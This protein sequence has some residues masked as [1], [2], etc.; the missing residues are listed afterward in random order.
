MDRRR[1]ITGPAGGA[2]VALATGALALAAVA[3]SAMAS[4]GRQAGASAAAAAAAWKIVYKHH[5]GVPDSQNGFLTLVA[6]SQRQA[7]AFGGSDNL[8]GRPI[9]ARLTGG[10]WRYAA[11]PAGLTGE[12]DAASASS[13]SNVWA[14][15]QLGQVV[16]HWNG[17][18]WSV[19]KRWHMSAEV[20]LTG[21]TALSPTDVWVFG[22]GG[23]TGGLGTWH[24]NGRTWKHLTRG[25]ANG[26]T[27]ASAVSSSNMWGIGSQNAPQD[28][29]VHYSHGRWQRQTAAALAHHQFQAILALSATSV[30]AIAAPAANQSTTSLLHFNGRS[31]SRVRVP[32]TAAQ[33]RQLETINADGHGGF[34]LVTLSSWILHRTAA[35]RWTRPQRNTPHAFRLVPLPGTSTV[36]APTATAEP[37]NSIGGDAAIFQTKGLG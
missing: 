26:I 30:W 23:F 13:P 31:W 5:Y 14:V 25:A 8:G 11:L 32:G 4:D 21:V 16:L 34:W 24:Y 17:R 20:E 36:L 19:A 27:L 22:S 37:G 10:R 12:I 28:S 3:P 35:G 2:V 33:V 18:R 6:P 7:W 9:A 1:S 15:S 29:I